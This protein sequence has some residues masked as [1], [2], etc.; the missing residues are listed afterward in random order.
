[1]RAEERERERMEAFQEEMWE[2]II[3]GELPESVR[4]ERREGMSDALGLERIR[5]EGLRE[6]RAE[7]PVRGRE[8]EAD[9]VVP[10]P[11]VKFVVRQGLAPSTG[12]M[13]TPSIGR[14]K[15]D[16]KGPLPQI[17]PRMGRRAR[18][19]ML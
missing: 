2:K 10:A 19:K 9:S 16:V 11:R 4:A 13:N 12:C 6:Q 3:E 1:M 7:F 5:R 17:R 8:S 14:C 18:Q 15:T